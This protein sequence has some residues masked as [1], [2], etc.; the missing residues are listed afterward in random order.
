MLIVILLSYSAD[1][2]LCLSYALRL[3][4]SIRPFKNSSNANVSQ[5]MKNPA[6][7]NDLL[8]VLE[9]AAQARLQRITPTRRGGGGGRSRRRRLALVTRKRAHFLT[10]TMWCWDG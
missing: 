6:H 5:S 4:P 1:S 3:H 8:H 2:S 9:A 7:E 10:W